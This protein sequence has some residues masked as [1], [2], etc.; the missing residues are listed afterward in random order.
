MKRGGWYQ[1]SQRHRLARQ[2]IRTSV[3]RPGLKRSL[4]DPVFLAQKRERQLPFP[5]IM[6]MVA[7]GLTLQEMMREHPDVEPDD[8]RRRGI[9]A[10]EA[11]EG[12]RMLSTLNSKGVDDVIRMASASTLFKREAQEV[13]AD[14]QKASFL[15]PEKAAILEKRLS[16]L[17]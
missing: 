15:H 11:R 8:L 3:R 7:Q 17:D 1:D 5:E 9:D 13:L 2:G 12:T 14:R 10:I 4:M 6:R 16:E